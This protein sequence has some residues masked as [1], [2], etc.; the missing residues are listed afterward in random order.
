[1]RC[2]CLCLSWVWGLGTKL[3][4][5]HICGIMLLLRAVLNMIVSPRGPM[6]FRC[7]HRRLELLEHFNVL[8]IYIYIYHSEH[9]GL[10]FGPEGCHIIFTSSPFFCTLRTWVCCACDP[11]VYLDVPFIGLVC[12][13]VCRKLYLSNLHPFLYKTANFQSSKSSKTLT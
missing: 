9:Y 13:C 6:C 5:F 7:H 11:S 12:V 10:R 8:Y 3:A 4:N 2:P 1:M